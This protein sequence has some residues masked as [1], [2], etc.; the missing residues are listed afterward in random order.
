[1]ETYTNTVLRAHRTM[2]L[3]NIFVKDYMSKNVKT[4]E[5]DIFQ[6]FRSFKHEC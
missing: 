2:T 4:N 3:T 6:L 5:K 1:M